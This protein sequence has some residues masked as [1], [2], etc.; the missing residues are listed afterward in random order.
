[1]PKV[2]SRVPVSVRHLSLADFGPPFALPERA[3][4][5]NSTTLDGEELVRLGSS[6]SNSLV[7][8]AA[9]RQRLVWTIR[10]LAPQLRVCFERPHVA[11]GRRARCR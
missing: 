7:T 11:F 2:H 10:E 5:R 1:L 3:E 9:E 8:D 6:P 4:G